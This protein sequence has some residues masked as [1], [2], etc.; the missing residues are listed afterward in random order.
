MS[1]R[2]AYATVAAACVLPRLAVLFKERDAILSEFVEKSDTLA[3]VFLDSGTF[4]FVPG[5]PSA[6]TQ[7][8][9]G[10]FLVVVYWI[11]GAHWWTIGI[12]QLVVALGSAFIVL[13]IGRRYLS[14]RAGVIAAVVATLEPY[15]VWHDMHANRE[16]LDQP[17]GAAMFL[18][19]LL[20][21]ER[22]SWRLVGALGVVS[23][24]AILSNSRLALLPVVLGAYLLWR[25]AGWLGAIVVPLVAAAALMPW[26]IRNAVQVGCFSLTT[27]ARALWKANNVSTWETLRAGHWID[28]VPDIP[29]R[30]AR[31]LTTPEEAGDI[32]AQ[33]GRKIAVDECAQQ[34][35]Y[36]HLVWQ[37]WLHHPG[38]KA[39]LAGQATTMLWDPRVD[40]R[41]GRNDEGASLDTWRRYVE[42]VY[43]VPLFLLAIAGLLAV[44]RT[45]RV[46]ALA[47]VAY[48]TLAAWAFVGTTRY[49]VP[50]DF[51]LALLAAAAID[52]L[53]VSGA[54]GRL[55]FARPSSQKR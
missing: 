50:W 22:R 31:G 41:A 28:D 48:E 12:A 42:P 36:Q 21:A 38:E 2:A 27:D 9:Y 45:F 55:P 39:K 49:R 40:L 34:S 11:A 4:G 14:A 46:L 17:L 8:L 30:M 51:V 25:G 3:R 23:G 37:F 10:W 54:G 35:F 6:Y 29:N 32:Y 13:E 19:T 26:M 7:P 53:L 43:A 24:L 1:R 5:E 20:A 15:L 33:S 16:V 52:R 44:T 47:F 18:L